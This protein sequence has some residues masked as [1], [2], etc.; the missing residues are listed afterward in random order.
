MKEDEH[1]LSIMDVKLKG[2]V[3][4]EF[5]NDVVK[6]FVNIELGL[7]KMMKTKAKKMGMKCNQ[8]CRR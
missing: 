4:Y 3:D 6:A 1:L 2:D 7:E 5:H 8:C